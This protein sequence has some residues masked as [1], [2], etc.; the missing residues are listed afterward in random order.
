[1]LNSSLDMNLPSLQIRKKNLHAKT[2]VVIWV[3]YLKTVHDYRKATYLY[4]SKV[5]D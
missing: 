1:M 2:W 4:L 5:L 3:K